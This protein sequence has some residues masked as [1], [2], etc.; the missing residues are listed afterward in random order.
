MVLWSHPSPR[1]VFAFCA[2]YFILLG[3]NLGGQPMALWLEPKV[4][5]FLLHWGRGMRTTGPP[6]FSNGQGR[7]GW[8][9]QGTDI[10]PAPASYLVVGKC[11]S[12]DNSIFLFCLLRNSKLHIC[13]TSWK[14]SFPRT[15]DRQSQSWT[16]TP[17][18]C[19]DVSFFQSFAA[20]N[21]SPAFDFPMANNGLWI[22][23]YK[24]LP[25]QAKLELSQMLSHIQSCAT[26]QWECVLRSESLGEF[27]VV[28]TSYRGSYTP[29]WHT[30][31]T[32][33]CPAWPVLGH[34]PVQHITVQ[35][36]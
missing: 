34:K 22:S 30:C 4:H 35:A 32:P 13:V 24:F 8:A 29:R 15:P 16:D 10:S 12:I 27:M 26:W 18:C 7:G 23:K 36:A 9:D 3:E 20:K 1:P 28:W 21:I 19:S 33:G 31:S 14:S 25:L 2:S 6:S 11:W 17:S 5:A